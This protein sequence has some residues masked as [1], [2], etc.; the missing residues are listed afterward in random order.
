MGTVRQYMYNL[1][2]TNSSPL[3][4][5]AKEDHPFLLFFL[6]YFQSFS[7]WFRRWYEPGPLLVLL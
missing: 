2:E 5:V 6:A 1:P 4:L 3:K 7:G